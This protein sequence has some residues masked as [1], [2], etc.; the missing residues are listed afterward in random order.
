MQIDSVRPCARWSFDF[1]RK[2]HCRM[3]NLVQGVRANL[4]RGDGKS[5]LGA[6]VSTFF[7]Y[8]LTG[9]PCCATTAGPQSWKQNQATPQVAQDDPHF[10]IHLSNPA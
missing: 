4:S 8:H 6:G 7:P 10:R 5:I 2:W 9:T 3:K 1:D